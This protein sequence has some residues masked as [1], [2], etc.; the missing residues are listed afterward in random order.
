MKSCIVPS[1]RAN[2]GTTSSILFLRVTDRTN[3]LF[4]QSF[5]FLIGWL[6]IWYE[7]YAGF[8]FFMSKSRYVRNKRYL[9]TGNHYGRRISI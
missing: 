4:S 9:D 5:A 3:D 8:F 6:C 2:L 1:R 7:F